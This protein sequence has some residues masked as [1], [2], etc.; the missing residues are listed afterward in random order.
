MAETDDIIDAAGDAAE[1]GVK[2]RKVNDRET[3]YF[4][5]TERINAAL[6]QAAASRSPFVRVGFKSREF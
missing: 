3:E 5:P 1:S 4:S 6:L 2:R